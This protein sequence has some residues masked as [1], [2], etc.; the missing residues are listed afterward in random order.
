[1]THTRARL[2]LQDVTKSDLVAGER[3][4]VLRRITLDVEPGDVVW[5]YGPAGSG[6][7]ALINVAGL[8]TTPTSGRVLLD[9]I[10]VTDA[11]D[12]VRTELR[13]RRVGMIF[14]SHNLLPELT[15]LEN[16]LLAIR[17]GEQRLVA[18]E[19]LCD[20]GLGPQLNTRAKLLS[21]GQQQ[22]VAVARALVNQPILLLADEPVSGLDD[23]TASMVLG[24]LVKAAANGCGVVISSHDASVAGIATRAVA[25]RT[26]AIV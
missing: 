20:I 3:S 25:L 11:A 24:E 6:T 21:E 14:H 23:Q 7:S 16:V 2:R 9:G 22:R 1:M 12:S 26:G 10:D 5:V 17:S 15:A 4:P 18:V 13:S 19:L 8:L